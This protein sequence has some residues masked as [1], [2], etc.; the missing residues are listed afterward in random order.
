MSHE[1]M[2]DPMG[3][4]MPDESY[5]E[6]YVMI[7]HMGSHHGIRT[8]VDIIIMSPIWSPEIM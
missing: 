2:W 3:P 4:D 8:S 1:S 5:F 7:P 6:K